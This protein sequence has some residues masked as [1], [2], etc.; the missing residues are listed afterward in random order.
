MQV[1]S[2]QHLHVDPL[3]VADDEGGAGGHG[4]HLALVRRLGG[5]NLELIFNNLVLC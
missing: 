3:G 2:V 5:E 4:V 1:T